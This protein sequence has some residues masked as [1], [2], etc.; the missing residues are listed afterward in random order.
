MGRQTG[1]KAP[2]T[3]FVGPK[4]NRMFA[5]FQFYLPS[6]PNTQLSTAG[7][8][9]DGTSKEIVRAVDTFHGD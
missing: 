8:T 4:A 9:Q 1:D 6:T 3:A 2:I 7:F 5:N